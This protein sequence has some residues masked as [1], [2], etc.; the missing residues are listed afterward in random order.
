MKKTMWGEIIM[1]KVSAVLSVLLVFMLLCGCAASKHASARS[2]EADLNRA[3]AKIKPVLTS[4]EKFAR[5]VTPF[6][7]MMLDYKDAVDLN[8]ALRGNDFRVDIDGKED[9]ERYIP[10]YKYEEILFLDYKEKT[11]DEKGGWNDFKIRFTRDLSSKRP[12]SDGFQWNLSITTM[13]LRDGA[14]RAYP[15]KNKNAYIMY[16]TDRGQ[17]I[18]FFVRRNENAKKSDWVC[19]GAPAIMAKR[20]SFADYEPLLKC[21]VDIDTL[22]AAD[23]ALHALS[24]HLYGPMIAYLNA[25]C[26]SNNCTMSEVLE[27][28]DKFGDTMTTAHILTDGVIIITWGYENG[29]FIVNTFK[30]S[31]KFIYEA[32]NGEI[33]YR[34]NEEDYVG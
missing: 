20:V 10:V 1:K 22:A 7:K 31:D 33:C 2:K 6:S 9:F 5:G 34:I 23:P 11:S 19:V 15:E 26:K 32:Y 14:L 16:D 30:Y 4:E 3:A 28:L 25:C 27:I 17:R 13:Y 29:K 18:F 21:G 12:F 8:D 24:D